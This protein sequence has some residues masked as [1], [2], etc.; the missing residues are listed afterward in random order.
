MNDFCAASHAEISAQWS[1]RAPY[2][3]WAISTAALPGGTRVRSR[4][5][6]SA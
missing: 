2:Q 3:W 6:S 5:I 4:E 1:S